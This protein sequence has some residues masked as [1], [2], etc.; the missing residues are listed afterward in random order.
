LFVIETHLTE[1]RMKTLVLMLATSGCLLAAPALAG[2][3][4]SADR[5]IVVADA[6]CVGP[7]CV[8]VRDHDREW[9]DR[10]P[11]DGDCREVEVR[12]RHGDDVVIRKRRTCD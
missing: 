12:E 10:G 9:R 11:R 5:P 8:G 1:D 6:L 2:A 3:P 4:A 7:A